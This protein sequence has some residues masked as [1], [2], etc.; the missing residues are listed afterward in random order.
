MINKKNRS[1]D[2]VKCGYLEIWSLNFKSNYSK[3][4]ELSKHLMIFDACY[5]V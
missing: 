5:T 1:S 3:L 2:A 4:Y